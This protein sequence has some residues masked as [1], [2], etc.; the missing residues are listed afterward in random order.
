MPADVYATIKH[1]LYRM[2]KKS[3]RFILKTPIS[4]RAA[5]ILQQPGLDSGRFFLSPAGEGWRNGVIFFI[6]FGSG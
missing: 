5:V 4:P 3:E 1:S 6:I 2:M